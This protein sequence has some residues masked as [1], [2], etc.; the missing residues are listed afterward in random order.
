M[1]RLSDVMS[2]VNPTL[3]IIQY[4]S[5]AC[6]DVWGIPDR[7]SLRRPTNTQNVIQTRLYELHKSQVILNQVTIIYIALFTMQIVYSIKQGNSVSK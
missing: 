1:Q 2:K 7:I 6:W 4:I 5:C 3:F